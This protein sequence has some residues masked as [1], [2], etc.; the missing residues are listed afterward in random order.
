MS[1][2]GIITA[3]TKAMRDRKNVPNSALSQGFAPWNEITVLFDNST[4]T[5][6]M[7]A[8]ATLADLA[9]R[10]TDED[11]P[12]HRHMLAVTIKFTETKCRVV[13]N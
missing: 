8:A 3:E 12:Q 11:G 1:T 4:V 13:R 6:P 10:L 7:P 9:E 5:F 2:A